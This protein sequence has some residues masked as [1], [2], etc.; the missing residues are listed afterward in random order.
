M[1]DA[2][3]ID[4][5]T[6]CVRQ[7]ARVKPDVPILPETKLVDDLGID[8]LDLVGVYLRIQDEFGVEVDDQDVPG[9]QTIS[10]LVRYVTSRS[11]AAAA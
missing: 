8:S 4:G 7:A 1:I 11:N 2:Q 9:L 3:M 5:I 10:D 6:L